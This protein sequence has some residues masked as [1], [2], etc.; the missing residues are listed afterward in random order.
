MEIKNGSIQMQLQPD[1]ADSI[2]HLFVVLTQNRSHFIDFMASNG[3]SIGLH[4]PVPCHLQEA[5]SHLGY[6]NGDFPIA[7]WQ[8]KSCCS[9]PMF[10]EMTDEEVDYV[11]EKV[12]KYTL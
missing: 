11:I 5:Y 12:N 8:A 2:Y 9:L 3:I 7:E 4:Y 1:W 10:A 6:K